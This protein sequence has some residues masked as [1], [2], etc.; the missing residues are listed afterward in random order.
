[1]VKVLVIVRRILWQAKLR[2]R[3]FLIGHAHRDWDCDG[4]QYWPNY[5]HYPHVLWFLRRADRGAG[6]RWHVIQFL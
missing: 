1:M 5:R 2:R 3:Q 6:S 4:H